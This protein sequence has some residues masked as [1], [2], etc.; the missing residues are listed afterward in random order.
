MYSRSEARDRTASNRFL[1]GLVIGVE[2]GGAGTVRRGP[3]R[4]GWSRRTHACRERVGPMARDRSANYVYRRSGTR[5]CGQ[6]FRMA[7]R[8]RSCQR[9]G[10]AAPRAE[11]RCPGRRASMTTLRRTT[12]FSARLEIEDRMRKTSAT[13]GA[14]S[15]PTRPE[16]PTS[17]GGGG[18][19]FATRRRAAGFRL[20]TVYDV[21]RRLPQ[22]T[23]RRGVRVGSGASVFDS[24]VWTRGRPCCGGPRESPN[25]GAGGVVFRRWC[26]ATTGQS[27]P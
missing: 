25:N 12:L 6:S 18:L 24:S 21:C 19:T 8:A 10:V 7:A 20:G 13:A 1:R 15:P 5:S 3:G 17:P 22:A 16:D 27:E 26:G 11:L 23:A 9:Q 2:A 4:A 14:I